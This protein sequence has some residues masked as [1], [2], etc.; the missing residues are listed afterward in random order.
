VKFDSVAII[1]TDGR[2]VP[3][4]ELGPAEEMRGE[5]MGW[6]EGRRMT[7]LQLLNQARPRPR[8]GRL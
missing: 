8:L 4:S 6:S 7:T 3:I 5:I 2:K 1:T